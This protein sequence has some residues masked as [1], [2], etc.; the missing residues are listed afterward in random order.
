MPGVQ[1]NNSTSNENHPAHCRTC[2]DFKS[3]TKQ[4]RKNTKQGTKTIEEK[5]TII[6]QIEVDRS[7]LNCPLDKDELGRSTWNLLHTMAAT[8]PEKPSIQQTENVKSFFNVLS[9]VYPCEPCAKDL[10]VE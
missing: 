6:E 8:Y 7:R 9:Q 1:P 3:W 4:Q 10:V 5:T 2:V